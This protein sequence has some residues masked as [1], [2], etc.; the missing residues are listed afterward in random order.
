MLADANRESTGPL[1]FEDY[2]DTAQEQQ[3][4]ASLMNL[5][6]QG[7]RVLEIGA[8]D[9]YISLRLAERFD[10]VTALDLEK[11]HI[12]HPRITTVKGDVRALEFPDRSFSAVLCAEVLEHIPPE[13]LARACRELARVTAGLLVVGV[14]YR[15]DLRC[16]RTTCQHCRRSNPPYGHV[17]RFDEHR[18]DRLFEG[19]EPSATDWIG[20]TREATNPLSAWL[21]EQAGNP[22]GT[23]TQDEPCIHCGQA[24]GDPP[25]R[26]LRA[27]LLSAAGERL[28][29]LQQRLSRP[30]PNWIH[31]SY[32]RNAAMDD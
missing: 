27:R 29:R 22:W 20:L 21:M 23:Y 25:P 13:D 12:P 24:I 19:L 31:R 32:R 5:L 11:V 7:G 10:A 28:N 1:H 9:G 18:L 2:R 30:R 6:P 17:N 14:P 15:Q 16:A 26:D 8:R 3:R 4:I